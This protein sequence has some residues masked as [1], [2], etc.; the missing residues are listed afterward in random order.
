M[1]ASLGE[2]FSRKITPQLIEL[3][4]RALEHKYIGSLT[5]GAEWWIKNGEQFPKPAQLLEAISHSRP[6]VSNEAP[7]IPWFGSDSL[8]WL[9]Q[10]FLAWM[11]RRI[12]RTK[13]SVGGAENKRRRTEIIELANA[14]EMMIS[15]EDPEA[16]PERLRA[17]FDV[18]MQR[19]DRE[20]TERRVA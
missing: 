5:D 7:Q 16:T 12:I 19:M 20:E 3:Y 2:I 11:G 17:M 4:W 10:G 18:L 14:H 8:R 15:E 9:N 13:R 6:A 1:M